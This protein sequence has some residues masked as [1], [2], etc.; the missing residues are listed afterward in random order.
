MTSAFSKSIISSL[1]DSDYLETSAYPSSNSQHAISDDQF[2]VFSNSFNNITYDR[3]LQSRAELFAKNSVT[4]YF[5]NI[6]NAFNYPSFQVSNENMATNNPNNNNKS[7]FTVASKTDIHKSFDNEVGSLKTGDSTSD[8]EDLSVDSDT[9]SQIFS[10]S[11]YSQLS[12]YS[13]PSSPLETLFNENS[14]N[15]ILKTNKKCL[16]NA[17]PNYKKKNRY[18]CK[19]CSKLFSRPSSLRT[20]VNTHT[21]D[22]PFVCPY[23]NCSKEF[24]AR[25]NMTRHYKSHFKVSSGGYLLPSGEIVHEKPSLRQLTADD[26]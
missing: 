19:F 25:S 7:N 2:A 11:E 20:H 16:R 4:E 9:M 10:D 24:N 21:G 26:M 23:E 6:Y 22:R 18:G 15:F 12:S 3:H 14:I 13:S 8:S 17:L 5:A 1:L